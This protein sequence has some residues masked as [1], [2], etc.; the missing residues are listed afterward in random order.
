M[1]TTGP[2]TDPLILSALSLLQGLLLLHPPSRCLFASDQAMNTILDLLDPTCNPPAVQSQGLLVLVSALMSEP[3]NARCFERVDGLLSVTH[4][5]KN[6]ATT[7]EVKMRT[8]EFLYFYL[9]PEHPPRSSSSLHTPDKLDRRRE[10][11]L[12]LP[13]HAGHARTHSGEM[14]LDVPE[15]EIEAEKETRSTEEKQKLLGKH[16]SNVEDL[17]RDLKESVPFGSTAASVG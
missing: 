2:Q 14:D 17:V 13:K 3:R 5:F 4:L 6:R 8:L 7:Q 12:Q 9:M 11:K 16:L 10:Q 15:E 1:S